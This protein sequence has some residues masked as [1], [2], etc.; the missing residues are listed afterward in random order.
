MKLQLNPSMN[1][2]LIKKFLALLLIA[3]CILVSACAPTT[4][5]VRHRI[6]HTVLE[7][8]RLSLPKRVVLLPVNIPV[9]QI[10]KGPVI[11]QLVSRSQRV[12][13]LVTRKI[14][15]Y[16]KQQGKFKL[17]KLPAFSKREM[18][19]IKEHKVL[20][21]LVSR[22]AVNY[23][24]GARLEA[25]NAKLKHFD[26]SIGSG[27]NFI[28][29]KTTAQAALIVTG[30]EILVDS[31]ITGLSTKTYLIMG[32]VDLNSGAILWLD[33]VLN[34]KREF[35]QRNQ[36]SFLIESMLNNYPGLTAYRRSLK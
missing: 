36:I 30:V 21:D 14:R 32:L 16:V 34:T 20:Y 23:T 2:P 17:L 18:L 15:S 26:Y 5:Q 3:Q 35:N 22:N 33:Y 31:K 10:S 12:N 1:K 27:L 13:E 29:R 7:N 19:K 4:T 11:D 28:K 8:Q 24:T 25:W 6:H 9:L